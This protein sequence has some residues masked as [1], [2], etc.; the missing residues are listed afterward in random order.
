M[1]V[2]ERRWGDA[3]YIDFGLDKGHGVFKI[4]LIM[5]VSFIIHFIINLDGWGIVL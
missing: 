3:F 1:A 5:N 2:D 4:I